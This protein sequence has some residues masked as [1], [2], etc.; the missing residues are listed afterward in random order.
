M[1]EERRQALNVVLSFASLK[2]REDNRM[3]RARTATT[4]T[5][6]RRRAEKLRS[7]FSRRRHGP[8]RWAGPVDQALRAMQRGCSAAAAI[9]P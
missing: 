9:S 3:T 1:F 2:L 7:E 5:E 8:R 4:L 6:A